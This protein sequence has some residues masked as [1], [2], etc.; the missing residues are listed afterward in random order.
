MNSRTLGNYVADIHILRLSK[1]QN[2]L[3]GVGRRCHWGITSIVFAAVAAK[4]LVTICITPILSVSPYVAILLLVAHLVQW[5]HGHAGG[6]AANRAKLNGALI[7]F[8]VLV[9]FHSLS[10]LYW[11][12]LD[13]FE[14]WMLVSKQLG[15]RVWGPKI[16]KRYREETSVM[17]RENGVLPHYWNLITFSVGLLESATRVDCLWGARVLDS[18]VAKG[19][20]I[21][22][23]LLSSSQAIQNLVEMIGLTR[24][25]NPEIRERAARI[26]PVL[27]SELRTQFPDALRCMCCLLESC[28]QYNDPMVAYLSEN[29]EQ[30]LDR[31]SHKVS[32]CR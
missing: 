7:L 14:P 4:I 10:V 23:E 24:A 19:I 5:D 6:D 30:T 17:C 2:Q 25:A 1:G 20:L 18:S 11:A 21:R 31:N 29:S 8:Y 13:R 27:A 22:Q 16:V 12:F 26:V 28:K 32:P 15:F 9:I 3:D